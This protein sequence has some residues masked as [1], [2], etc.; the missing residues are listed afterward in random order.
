MRS[1]STASLGRGYVPPLAL[2]QSRQARLSSNGS[3]RLADIGLVPF[4]TAIDSA[5]TSK[6]ARSVIY[7]FCCGCLPSCFPPPRSIVTYKLQDINEANS[8]RKLSIL[9]WLREG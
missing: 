8:S 5:A 1:R 9:L 4:W 7:L 3:V 6:Q 2:E